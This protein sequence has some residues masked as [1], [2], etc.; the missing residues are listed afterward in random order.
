MAAIEANL[1]ARGARI[2][3]RHP[4]TKPW[5]D[6][7]AALA[8]IEAA[9]IVLVNGEGTVH[10]GKPAAADLVAL[11][12][13]C[14][15][16]AK[17]AYMINA[18]IQAN[19]AEM[20]RALAAF[21]GC[22]VRESQSVEE[23]RRAGVASEIC[24]DLSFF[25]HLPRH[26]RG[27]GRGL[28]LDAAQPSV[29]ARLAATAAALKADFAAMRHNKTG[30]KAY[31]KR[32]LSRRYETDKPLGIVPGIVTFEQFARDLA[33][34][35]FLVTGRFHGLCFALNSRVP[36]LAVPLDTWKTEGVLSDVGL[37][38]DRLF[39]GGAPDPLQA[40]EQA[41]ITAYLA[42]IRASI[43]VMFDRVLGD[44]AA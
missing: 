44:Q 20:M 9:D 36:F 14:A 3:Y 19:G 18:T 43:A 28:V 12:P 7:P 13:H 30:M 27:S 26:D 22:W 23:L 8:A 5:R 32:L 29:T 39:R 21:A 40:A 42:D 10:H 41:K 1:A 34:R 38:P 35:R 6:D 16:L 2:I 17:P 15:A 33:R 11:G 25:H 24:G 37:N 4:V 31:R